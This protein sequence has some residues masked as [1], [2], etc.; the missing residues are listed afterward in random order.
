[1]NYLDLKS[2]HGY[3]TII[4]TIVAQLM[5][6]KQVINFKIS[7]LSINELDF[8]MPGHSNTIGTLLKHMTAI[9]YQNSI[10]LFEK[11]ELN[12][13]EKKEWQGSLPGNLDYGFTRGY[14]IVD[15]QNKWNE[16]RGILLNHLLKIDDD[17]LFQY[18]QDTLQFYGNNYYILFHII[19][20]QL[21]HY[22]QIKSI[23][24]LL[25]NRI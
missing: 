8:E 16:I 18:P 23:L 10:L 3:S 9:E 11:R 25:P 5:M 6:T 22:G 12:D 20:D 14:S 2:P 4:G 21:C 15:Y 24:N 1:M 13:H 19:E 17:W 7:D